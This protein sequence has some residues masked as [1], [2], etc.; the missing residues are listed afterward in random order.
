MGTM[1]GKAW[2]W[3]GIAQ[4]ALPATAMKNTMLRHALWFSTS[5]PKL[6]RR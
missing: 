1:L 5:K 2:T 3:T 4:I 6:I